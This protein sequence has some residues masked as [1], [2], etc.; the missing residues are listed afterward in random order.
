MT[1]RDFP[2]EW[3]VDSRFGW[4]WWGIQKMF[5]GASGIEKEVCLPSLKAGGCS[6]HRIQPTA[7]T[8]FPSL[9]SPSF[10]VVKG[11]NVIGCC[12]GDRGKVWLFPLQCVCT[13]NQSQLAITLLDIWCS[14]AGSG[15]LGAKTGS[16]L[17]RTVKEPPPGGRSWSGPTWG[18]A[19]PTLVPDVQEPCMPRCFPEYG[20]WWNFHKQ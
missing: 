5:R 11:Y 9:P 7:H 8:H 14:G 16:Y 17:L 2:S 12:M 20:F 18:A 4:W 10:T 15:W 6:N 1:D 13:L 3:L 19:S